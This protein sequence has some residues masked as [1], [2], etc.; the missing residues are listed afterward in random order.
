MIILQRSI[1]MN[2]MVI[3]FIDMK[4]HTIREQIITTNMLRIV[5]MDMHRTVIAVKVDL[6]VLP[7]RDIG[8]V[9]MGHISLV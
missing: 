5:D 1:I 6:R 9:T 7:V 4:H 3:T 2:T 8:S